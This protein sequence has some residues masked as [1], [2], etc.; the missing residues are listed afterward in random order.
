MSRPLLPLLCACLM[1]LILLDSPSGHALTPGKRTQEHTFWLVPKLKP[2]QNLEEKAHRILRQ[3]I[4]VHLKQRLDT[5][6][7][8]YSEVKLVAPAAIKVQI[9]SQKDRQELGRILFGQGKLSIRPLLRQHDL[10]AAFAGALPPPLVPMSDRHGSYVHSQDRGAL[11]AF[12]DTIVLANASLV[13]APDVDHGGWRTWWL[14][15][16]VVT[17]ESI[18]SLT[19]DEGTLGEPYLSLTLAPAASLPAGTYAVTMDGELLDRVFYTGATSTLNLRCEAGARLPQEDRRFCLRLV[20]A[21][22]SSVIPFDLVAIPAPKA[23][24]L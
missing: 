4:V 18:T 13:L 9:S 6:K 21:R 19:Y 5:M 20:Q 2:N 22:A 3:K 12:V 17:Q 24:A 8:H 15:A 7:I 10:L 23:P 16:P 11:Q 14:G 1:G